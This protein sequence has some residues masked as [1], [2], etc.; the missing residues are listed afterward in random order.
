MLEFHVQLPSFLP[1]CLSVCLSY[2]YVGYLLLNRDQEQN[3]IIPW[4]DGGG[5]LQSVCAECK[6]LN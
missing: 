4:K 5:A 2:F 6:W 3:F 1:L